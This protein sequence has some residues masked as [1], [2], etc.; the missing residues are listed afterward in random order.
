MHATVY[1]TLHILLLDHSPEAL[2]MLAQCQMVWMLLSM[3]VGW[4]LGS[5]TAHPVKDRTQLVTISTVALLHVLLVMWEQSY[6]ESHYTYHVHESL[7]GLLLILLRF[8][9]AGLFSYNLKHTV[10]KERSVLRKDFYRSFAIV[11]ES[12]SEFRSSVDLFEPRFPI[13]GLLSLVFS[14]SCP[15]AGHNSFFSVL[16]TQGK[17]KV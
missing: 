9:L 7:P 12:W 5:A 10:A 1:H 2:E 15:H 3:S 16:E 17:V 6:D 11:R 13:S 8:G 14:V 4:T